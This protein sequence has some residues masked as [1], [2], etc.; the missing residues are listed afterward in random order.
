MKNAY[1]YPGIR[2]TTN[3]NQLVSYYTES[4]LAEAGIF[5]PITP[6]TEMG[7][8]FQQSFAQGK[9]NV[10]GKSKVAIEAEGEHAAQGG[11]I[12]Y[13]VTGKRVVNF[14]SGQGLVY[15]GAAFFQAFT[16]CQPEHGVGDD[17]STIQAQRIRDSRGLPEFVFDPS[18]GETYAEAIDLKGNPSAKADWWQKNSKIMGTYDYT[19]A[20]WASTEAR[21]RRHFKKITEEQAADMVPLAN[22]LVR[23]TQNDVVHRRF[24]NQDHRAFVP[25]FGVAISVEN[26]RGGVDHLSLSRQMTLFCVE[27][28]KA[29][30]LLQSHAG[31]ENGDYQAQRALLAKVDA[32]EIPLDDLF[33]KGET[34]V[35]EIS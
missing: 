23:I 29:W 1:P 5:Y 26:D 17:M 8:L 25:D 11:A 27:R 22:M 20:H 12:A 13:S 28:R 32:G 2:I 31:I 30:R 3:G 21:F 6:S 16:T 15:R 10:F 14:T 24:L 34:L 18:H 35:K 33:D 7:E 19:V 4:R 9:L